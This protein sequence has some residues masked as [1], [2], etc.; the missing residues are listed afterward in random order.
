MADWNLRKNTIALV[1]GNGF[2]RDLRL[3]S[4]F[5]DFAKSDEWRNLTMAYGVN[6]YRTDMELSL[7]WLIMLYNLTGLILKKLFT[8]L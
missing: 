6:L 4:S 2:D 5:S 1:T 7:L 3:Q 8:N